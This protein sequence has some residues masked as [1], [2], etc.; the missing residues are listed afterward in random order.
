MLIGN[1]GGRLLD[2]NG[3]DKFPQFASQE[4]YEHYGRWVG[5]QYTTRNPADV[6]F[7]QNIGRAYMTAV[8]QSPYWFTTLNAH[9]VVLENEQVI[10]Y[11]TAGTIGSEL[12]FMMNN[13][14]GFVSRREVNDDLNSII[15]TAMSFVER[16]PGYQLLAGPLTEFSPNDV[17]VSGKC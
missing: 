11:G 6:E 14:F 9:G 16:I 8:S 13:T 7:I 5:A 12:K 10:T 4:A 17:L 1:L 2:Y 3:G 15:N